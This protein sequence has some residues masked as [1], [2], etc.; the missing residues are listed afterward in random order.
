MLRDTEI[1]GIKNSGLKPVRSS[2]RSIYC[3]QAVLDHFAGACRSFEEASDILEQDCLRQEGL[4]EPE[5]PVDGL[6]A[7][8]THPL[9]GSRLPLCRLTE[10]LARRPSRDQVK[11]SLPQPEIAR[12]QFFS[13]EVNIRRLQELP[14]EAVVLKC[15]PG[16]RI[17]LKTADRLQAGLLKPKIQTSR[18]REDTQNSAEL[19]FHVRP[20]RRI[21]DRG[22]AF[23]GTCQALS[24]GR[25]RTE[26][27]RLARWRA[28]LLSPFVNRIRSRFRAPM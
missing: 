27:G 23:T 21:Q 11:F 7:R 13:S 17:D 22:S 25:P 14:P 6:S 9:P 1:G 3:F 8:I 19:L 28:S 2:T 15:L 20:F 26:A 10:R 5:Q 16:N 12:P 4:Y 18:S 24:G